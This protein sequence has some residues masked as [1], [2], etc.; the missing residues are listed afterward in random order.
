MIAYPVAA[1]LGMLLEQVLRG[2][3]HSGRAV[4]ALQCIA[5]AK[6]GLQIGDLAAIRQAFDR[7]D[8]R[9]IR[10]NREHQACPYDLAVQANRA[11]AAHAMLAADMRSGQMQVLAQKVREIEPRQN[12]CIDAFAVDIER[13]WNRR[14]HAALPPVLGLWPSSAETQR[15]SSTFARCL[16]IEAVAC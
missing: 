13:D 11:S 5:I 1:R 8:M 2:H 3:Q 14:R 7:L 10:L 9:T 16:R 6:G 12:I 4:T 15:S